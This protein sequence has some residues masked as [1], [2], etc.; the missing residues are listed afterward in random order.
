MPRTSYENAKR[1]NKRENSQPGNGR[2]SFRKR[3]ENAPTWDRVNP[4][5]LSALVCLAT[6]YGASPTFGYTRDG[7]SLVMGMWYAGERHTDYL[8][9]AD[10]FAEYF[11]WVVNDLLQV[12]QED[13]QPYA[14]IAT[15][16]P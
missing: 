11:E 10:E 16:K 4:L 15:E 2:A 8:S 5:R 1:A 14:M 3:N 13:M 7:T 6:T 9:G 12:S